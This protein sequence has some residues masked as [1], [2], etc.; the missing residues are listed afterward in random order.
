MTKRREE[1]RKEE[2]RRDENRN[3]EEEKKN[4]ER[5]KGGYGGRAL[6]GV[7]DVCGVRLW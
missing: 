7:C 5:E 3:K 1:K 2:E 4:S 6:A